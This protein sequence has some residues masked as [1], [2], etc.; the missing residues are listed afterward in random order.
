MSVFVAVFD[1]IEAGVTV[2]GEPRRTPELT[3][4]IG[5]DGLYMTS[6][7]PAL[8]S[9]VSSC[10]MLAGS[11]IFIMRAAPDRPSMCSRSGRSRGKGG[12]VTFV[13]E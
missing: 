8:P 6:L 9:W 5:A 11:P 1:R 2:N 10:R 3:S 7:K 13:R 12:D 4:D